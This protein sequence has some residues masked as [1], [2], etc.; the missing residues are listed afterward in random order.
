M[1]II[2]DCNR[3]IDDLKDHPNAKKC[4]HCRS[5]HYLLVIVEHPYKEAVHGRKD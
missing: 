3:E 5:K 1:K 4:K 2:C